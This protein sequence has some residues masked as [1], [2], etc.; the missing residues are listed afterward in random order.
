MKEG[1]LTLDDFGEERER[2]ARM[3]S[4]CEE[5]LE[6]ILEGGKLEK[7][8]AEVLA[9]HRQDVMQIKEDAVPIELLDD[10]IEKIVVLSPE[11]IEITY[12]FTDLMKMQEQLMRKEGRGSA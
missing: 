1:M 6:E 7:E 2:L 4:Q 8:F 3:Q 10:L 11:R 5:E 12:T 9:K